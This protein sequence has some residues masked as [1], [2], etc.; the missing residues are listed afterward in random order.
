[1]R[2]GAARVHGE[3][4][5]A[6]RRAGLARALDARLRRQ[7]SSQKGASDVLRPRMSVEKN[8]A[9][10]GSTAAFSWEL[11]SIFGAIKTWLMSR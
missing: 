1:M 5:A 6:G 10:T 11:G 8:M 9:R 4:A 3:R 7:P 2:G